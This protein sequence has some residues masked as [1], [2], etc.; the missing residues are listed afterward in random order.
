MTAQV[1][2]MGHA[3]SVVIRPIEVVNP[4]IARYEKAWSHA[5]YRVTSPGEQHAMDFLRQARVEAGAEAL[6]LGCGTGRGALMLALFGGMRVTMIDFT[7]NCLDPEVAEACKT[8][9]DRIKFLRWDLTKTLPVSAAY[10]YCCDVM[11]HIPTDDVDKVL[12]NVLGSAQHCFFNISTVDDHF[13]P[14]LVGAPLHLTVRPMSWWVEKIVSIGAVIHWSKESEQECSIY[15]SSWKDASKVLVEGKINTDLAVVDAQVEKNV[16]D[17]WNHITPF[18]KQERE[19]IVLAGGPTMAGQID[20]IRELR[21][22]KAALVTVNGSYNWALDNGLEPSV[23]IV[24]DAR[25]FN[26]RFTKPITPFT[27]YLIASQAHPSTLD[28]LPR[29]RTW[30]WHS[31]LTPANETLIKDLTGQYFP[32]PGGSTVV[33]RAIPLLRMMGYWRMHLFGFDSCVMSDGRHHSYS[34]PENDKEFVIPVTCG[35]RTF[36]CTPW[37][38]SQASEFRDLIKFMGNEVELAVY[39]DGLIAQ[40]IETGASFNTQEH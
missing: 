10:G 20:K 19:V 29:D 11:E 37:M 15:C 38:L 6:D 40:I 17:G 26:N 14:V 35:G 1:G 34:Q 39:G 23:Q 18:D 28:G 27:K 9:P 4:E 16:R 24:L 21:A 36:E 31:G 32:V 22:E 25:E 13:G 30:L 12:R 5:E 7:D 8:Q 3:P 33:L 2:G